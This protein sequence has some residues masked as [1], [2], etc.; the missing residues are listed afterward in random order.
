MRYN[1][2][3]ILIFLII[4]SIICIL[5]FT[6]KYK[7]KFKYSKSPEF[8]YG[9][10][11]YS[12]IPNIIFSF[13]N[14][15]N[16]PETVKKCIKSWQKYNPLYT[17][18]M[19][20]FNNLHK[21]LNI[22]ITKLKQIKTIHQQSDL[23]RLC[24]LQ[25]YG[26]IW[27]DAT[28]YLNNSLNWIHACQSTTNCEYVGYYIDAFTK[29]YKYPVIENWF[30]ASIPNSKFIQDWL[31][32][33]YEINNFESVDD[34][35]NDIKLTTDLQK[36]DNPVYLSMHSACQYILQNNN[37]HYNLCL[38]K[39]EDGPFLYN[40]FINWDINK[41]HEYFKNKRLQTCVVKFR[42]CERTFIETHKLYNQL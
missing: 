2:I 5:T 24:L 11:E 41:L 21:Y 8:I 14:D 1:I 10:K 39:A 33:F 29:N 28:I 32:K 22:D 16:Y 36:I 30:I 15:E 38:F 35:I 37:I 27:L 4:I 42:G 23:I 9:T 19:V 17:I 26:G 7:E 34:Y 18:H 12:N 31:I 3:L 20:T 6:T 13:W 25:K 40:K